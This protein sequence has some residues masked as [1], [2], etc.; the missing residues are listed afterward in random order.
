MKELND[1][2]IIR[3]LFPSY[4]DGLTNE[5]TNQYIEEHLKDCEDCKKALKNMKKD[6][7]LNTTKKS[8]DEVKYIKKFNKKL[9][10]LKIILIGILLI[11]LFSYIR[12]IIILVSLNNKVSEYTSST[13]YYMKSISHSDEDLIIIENYKKDDRYIR[14]LK[15]LSEI[16]R[17]GITD[18]CNGE[19]V[20][21]YADM[22]L[23]K[24][25]EEELSTKTAKLNKT[26]TQ[27]KPVI[28]NDIEINNP[29]KLF[30]I[31]L[32]STITSEKLNEKDCYKIEMHFLN[33]DSGD[34]YYIDK[35][36]GL[37][38]RKTYI[39]NNMQNNRI[40]DIQYEFN[41]VT[42]EDFAEPDISDYEIEE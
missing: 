20:N 3:D 24:D 22:K 42:D 41:T 32:I 19:T 1:C 37:M 33:S 28:P 14:K 29:I 6:I 39:V 10:T 34:T 40:S 9:K 15:V 25:G 11:F 7:K 21:T 18:Y 38:I 26:D 5:T 17:S 16:S 36:T 35:E 30:I 27:P 2:K 31:P 4:I 13:N 8:S 12:N 23:Y